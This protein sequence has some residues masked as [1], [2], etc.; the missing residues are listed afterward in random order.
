M[1]FSFPWISIRSGS[2]ISIKSVSKLAKYL[3]QL[4]ISIIALLGFGP[5]AS[6]GSR[7]ISCYVSNSISSGSILPIRIIV[8]RDDTWARNR[9][10]CPARLDC[11][12]RRPWRWTASLMDLS[13][14]L[15]RIWQISHLITEMQDRIEECP[16]Q[17]DW[18]WRIMARGSHLDFEVRSWVDYRWNCNR[19]FSRQNCLEVTADLGVW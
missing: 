9:Q 18:S 19:G 12:G 8:C 17:W 2:L 16:K 15:W 3:S 13:W 4:F 11:T 5:W 6:R 7:S 14:M 10:K 1:G